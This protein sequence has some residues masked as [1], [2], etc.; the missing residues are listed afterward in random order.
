MTS[1]SR[2]FIARRARRHSY[3]SACVGS[4]CDARRAGRYEAANATPIRRA[5]A[6]PIATGSL[7]AM[8]NS[9]LSISREAGSASAARCRSDRHD[10]EIWRMTRRSTSA[11]PRPER[12]TNP[13]LAGASD[14]SSYETMP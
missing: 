14:P 7:G 8:P 3:L 6:D 5:S 1:D 9:R 2:R 4:S 13:D 11:R 12:H 10:D